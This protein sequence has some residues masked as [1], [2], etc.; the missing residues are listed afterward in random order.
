M[1]TILFL[2][3][4]NYFRSRFAEELFNHRAAHARIGWRARSRALA[5]EHLIGVSDRM[6]PFAVSGL[7]ESGYVASEAERLP[8]QCVRAD[9]E[10]ADHTVALNEPEHR[11]LMLERFPR[12]AERIEYWKVSD[13]DV[14]PAN[15][16]LAAIEQ[17]VEALLGRVGG[18]DR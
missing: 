11:P 4:G 17:Q 3:S 12:W 15:V 10:T 14:V 16:A 1:K 6:S 5:I 7:K 2:C 13:V 9:F 8:Q 18:D